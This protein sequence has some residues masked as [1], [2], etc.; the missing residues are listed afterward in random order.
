MIAV[1]PIGDT[2]IIQILEIQRAPL[3][4]IGVRYAP[5]NS[6]APWR[7]APLTQSSLDQ[8]APSEGQSAIGQ[9]KAEDRK[10]VV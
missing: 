8:S 7:D 10:S 6:I 3:R 2:F 4:S 1:R 5:Q 9:A